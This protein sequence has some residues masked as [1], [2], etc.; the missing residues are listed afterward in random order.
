MLNFRND[1][2]IC[3]QAAEQPEHE[4]LLLLHQPIN[5]RTS[6]LAAILPPPLSSP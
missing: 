1:T 3:G 2:G 6:Q 5:I 4:R